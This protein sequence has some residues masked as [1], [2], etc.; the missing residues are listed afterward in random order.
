MFMDTDTDTDD[1][2]A[3][4]YDMFLSCVDEFVPKVVIKD[5]NRPPW[6]DRGF[7]VG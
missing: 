7:I 6:I 5:A 1:S 2:T 3:C 4:W